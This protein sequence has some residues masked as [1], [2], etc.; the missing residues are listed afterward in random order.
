[1]QPRPD[2]VV[3]DVNETLSDMA[4]LAQLFEQSGA[5]AQL[6]RTWFA[7]VLRDG[8]GLAA[9]GAS[10]RF[11]DIAADLLRSLLR[12]AGVTDVDPAAERILSGFS[13]LDVHPDVP[14]GL[15]DLR[16]AGLTLATLTNGS[17]QTTEALLARAGVRQELDHVLSVEEAG[18]WKP[19]RG[20]YEHAARRCGVP[21]SSMVMV[22]VHPWDVDGAGRA[23]MRT[24]WVDR[25]GSSYPRHALPPDLT[26]RGVDQL[27]AHL[28]G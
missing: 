13:E 18:V 10:A 7:S 8:F 14:Q 9:A 26:V 16:V 17:V 11:T 19:A 4:P 2:V 15:R 28:V 3:L 6:A 1:M 5:P 25:T 24:A 21:L 22:A 20:A 23:G 12:E 27:A